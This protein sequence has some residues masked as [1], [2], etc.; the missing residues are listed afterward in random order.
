MWEFGDLFPFKYHAVRDLFFYLF[1]NPVMVIKRKRNG[2]GRLYH[3]HLYFCQINMISILIFTL[4]VC[5]YNFDITF[6]DF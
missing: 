6:K 2:I 3:V 4:S 1:K 5:N